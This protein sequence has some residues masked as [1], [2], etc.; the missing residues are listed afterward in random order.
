MS[1]REKSRIVDGMLPE[2]GR[3]ASKVP[4]RVRVEA[5]LHQELSSALRKLQD[6]RLEATSVTRVEMSDDLR[7]A[8]VFVRLLYGDAPSAARAA[9]MRALDTASG[10]LRSHVGDT[11]KLRYTPEL[12]F[13][14]DQGPDAAQRV[15]ELLAEIHEEEE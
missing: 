11:L 14:Y 10:R 6:P 4:R 12:R 1:R 7:F 3:P 8:R 13:A 2:L 15:E 9:L 5:E